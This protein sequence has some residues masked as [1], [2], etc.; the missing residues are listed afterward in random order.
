MANE[1]ILLALTVLATLTGLTVIIIASFVATG[2][3][4]KRSRWATTSKTPHSRALWRRHHRTTAT[5]LATS[6]NSAGHQSDVVKL[7]WVSAEDFDH[8]S[9]VLH[10]NN[11]DTEHERLLLAVTPQQHH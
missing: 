6:T 11:A 9:A 2:G 10:H 5:A 8:W 4:M 7:S 3:W 1:A